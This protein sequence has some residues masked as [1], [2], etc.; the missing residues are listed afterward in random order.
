MHHFT[1]RQILA[2]IDAILED[3][4]Q[5]QALVF[6]CNW[7]SYAGADFAGVSRLN[8]PANSRLIRTMCSGR[9]SEKFLWHAF[10]KGAPAILVSGCH[11]SDCHYINANHWTDRRIG[12]MWK[13]MEK[14]GIRKERLQLEWISRGGRHSL[15]AGHGENGNHPEIRHCRGDCPDPGKIM[16]TS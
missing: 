14:K 13:K 16:N 5:E 11:L 15:S 1:D 7:C 3:Q 6:A 10:A 12:R 8:Y 2:Q 9:V 4:P